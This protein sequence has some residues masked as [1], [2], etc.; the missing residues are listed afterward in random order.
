MAAHDK[1]LVILKRQWLYRPSQ[2]LIG[3]PDHLT[4]LALMS[5][6]TLFGHRLGVTAVSQIE[7]QPTSFAQE[8]GRECGCWRASFEK[9]P[10]VLSPLPFFFTSVSFGSRLRKIEEKELAMDS[11]DAPVFGSGSQSTFLLKAHL[12]DPIPPLSAASSTETSLL[13]SKANSVQDI[14][15]CLLP[16]A[17]RFL[18]GFTAD[19]FF[20]FL[21]E[22]RKHCLKPLV[23]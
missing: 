2:A 19:F 12:M 13:P 23:I 22:P 17:S 7:H 11:P 15:I 21:K 18:Q 16:N 10:R 6:S 1:I 9:P 14:N 20:F 4:Y 3:C 5:S 8:L